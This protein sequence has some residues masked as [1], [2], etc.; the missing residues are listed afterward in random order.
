MIGACNEAVSRREPW[1]FGR[2]KPYGPTISVFLGTGVTQS[3]MPST[4]PSGLGTTGAHSWRSP[5][6][7]QPLYRPHNHL[8]CYLRFILE[9]RQLG[10]DEAW[11]FR[12]SDGRMILGAI[13]A[14]QKVRGKHYC[15]DDCL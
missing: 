6:R 9:A 15:A 3:A 14:R 5:A 10:H 4:A 2:G 7:T 11:M 8:L 13:S 1:H 12:A